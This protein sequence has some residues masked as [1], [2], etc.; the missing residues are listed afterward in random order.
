MEFWLPLSLSALALIGTLL[1][2]VYI[3]FSG[4]IAT[5]RLLTDLQNEVQALGASLEDVGTRWL[6]YRESVDGLLEELQ[7][8]EERVERGRKRTT[9]AAARMR[10]QERKQNG[11]AGEDV[12][13]DAQLLARARAMGLPV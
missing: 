13:E 9:R 4:P 10:E 6:Q 2:A 11:D 12:D 8:T 7:A 1:G 5:R 3:R